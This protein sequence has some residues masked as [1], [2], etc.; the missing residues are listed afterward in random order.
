MKFKSKQTSTPIN[1]ELLFNFETK[2]KTDFEIQA[3]YKAKP[4]YKAKF[5]YKAKSKYDANAKYNFQCE[6][7]AKPQCK[8]N[9]ESKTRSSQSYK[10]KAE[11]KAEIRTKDKSGQ[12]KFNDEFYSY[13]IFN[14]LEIE[15]T[16]EEESNDTNNFAKET[17]CNYNEKKKIKTIKIKRKNKEKVNML[18]KESSEDIYPEVIR[19]R[20]CMKTHFPSKKL[21][22]FSIFKIQGN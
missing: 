3:E 1:P 9:L 8:V 11:Y 10:S 7:K 4:K 6:N 14:H 12:D 17:H 15:E 20:G 13:N 22:K 21:C 2:A 16:M 19:C 5:E 18:E